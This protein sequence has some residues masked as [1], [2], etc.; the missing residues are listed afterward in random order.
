M[1]YSKK[2]LTTS[3][4]LSASKITNKSETTTK[5][6]ANKFSTFQPL[7]QEKENNDPTNATQTERGRPS[8]CVFVASLCSSV[9]DDELCLSV[10]NLFEKWGK[11]TRVKVLRDTKN[12]PYAFV[13]Y[14]SDSEAAR[15]IEKAQGCTLYERK[16]RCE[17]AKVN[18]TL[19]LEQTK[20]VSENDVRIMLSAFGPIE[21]LVSEPRSGR[22][23]MSNG[24]FC[25]FAYRDDAITAFASLA[26]ND[27]Y[28]L[29][30][31]QNVDTIRFEKSCDKSPKFDHCCIFIGQLSLDTTEAELRERFA[32]HGE[33]ESLSIINTRE[34]SAF[35]FL[36]YTSERSAARA[37][38]AENHS[39]FKR[40]TMHVQ[41][42]EYTGQ[43]K[44]FAYSPTGIALAP[45]PIR[46]HR[47]GM[48]S[49]QESKPV[50]RFR[51]RAPMNFNLP[52]V[53][54]KKSHM[55]E[56]RKR[57][58]NRQSHL[59]SNLKSGPF[60]LGD[61]PRRAPSTRNAFLHSAQQYSRRSSGF[62]SREPH[63][64]GMP[65]YYYV[66]ETL[67]YGGFP[68]YP[69]TSFSDENF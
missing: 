24:W 31:A 21:H 9:V 36:R 46:F 49:L 48:E 45:P 59:S 29:E 22:A 2:V 54:E 8:S 58:N 35:A 43:R 19:Y 50:T 18:R 37:V 61:S 16:I 28:F 64:S 41:F 20:A 10:T 32:P 30:W 66:P 39:L 62:S 17:P 51:E 67:Y 69:P 5:P 7:P 6:T 23:E 33:I 26:N 3:Q 34:R 27:K 25:Q 68:Y 55:N 56:K 65:Y 12:R 38:E 42:K 15:A 60:P 13:Q 47:H 1:S 63:S 44:S 52:M 11:I 14:T 40:K 57:S 53:E 4:I